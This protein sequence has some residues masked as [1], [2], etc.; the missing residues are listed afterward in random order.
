MRQCLICKVNIRDEYDFC[1]NCHRKLEK[2]FKNEAKIIYD[3]IKYDKISLNDINNN[4]CLDDNH[5]LL[6][7]VAWDNYH[8][9]AFG[10]SDLTTDEVNHLLEDSFI[11]KYKNKK[12]IEKIKDLQGYVI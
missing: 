11:T 9:R 8:Y 5:I 2:Q 3:T 1:V 7:Q 6:K 10:F 4:E 12:F